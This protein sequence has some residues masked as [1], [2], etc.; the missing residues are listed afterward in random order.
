MLLQDKENLFL[1]RHFRR[2]SAKIFGQTTKIGFYLTSKCFVLNTV[3]RTQVSEFSS[4]AVH[5]SGPYSKIRTAQGTNQIAP[6][7]LGP[8][9]PYN[10]NA[11]KVST[12]VSATDGKGVNGL[13]LETIAVC[14]KTPWVIRR[15]L[16]QF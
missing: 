5:L 12:S 9:Q 16:A 15:N 1:L 6:F 10:N 14:S 7:H 3:S 4:R 13:Q 8:V 2:I 11:L